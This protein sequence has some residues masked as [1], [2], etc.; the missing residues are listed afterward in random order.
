MISNEQIV[1]ALKKVVDPELGIDIYTLGL[2][3]QITPNDEKPIIKMTLTSP[4]CPYGPQVISDVKQKV[5]ALPGVKEVTVDLTF[6]PPWQ[7]SEDVK[8][9]LGIVM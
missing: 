8:L 6:E 1:E 5:G 2:I 7:P 3:Y 9:M 4:M